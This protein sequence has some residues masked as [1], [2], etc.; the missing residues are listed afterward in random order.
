MS[1]EE[2]AQNGQ[3]REP[4][5]R[6]RVLHCAVGIADA[7]GMAAVTM[8][9]IAAELGVKPMSLYYYVANKGALLDG[10][11][12][13]VFNEV[14]LPTN[15]GHWEAAMRVRAHSVRRALGRHPWAI[16]LLESRTEPGLATLR[17]HNATLGV[18]RQA[19]FSIA[20]SAHAYAL[21]DSF[22]Y[23]FALQENSLPF[24]GDGDDVAEIAAPMVEQFSGGEFPFLVEI[25]ME[26]VL[27]PGY[28]FGD[29]F[30]IGLT[31]ILEGLA[32]WLPR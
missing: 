16:G 10:L 1:V 7:Q 30:E 19:G 32:R 28:K 4:L 5:S 14:E 17:H 25:A 31:L 2:I 3:V 18:L 15:T 12:D 27:K 29:E 11:I 20:L 9:S 13:I 26:H 22:I 21:I 23:G 24:T 8:R 6:E